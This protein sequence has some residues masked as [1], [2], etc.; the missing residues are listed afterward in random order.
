MLPASSSSPGP[1]CSATPAM[2]G[3]GVKQRH[4]LRRIL[5]AGL[6]GNGHGLHPPDA[7]GLDIKRDPAGRQNPQIRGPP[8]QLIASTAGRFQHMLTVVEHQQRPAARHHLGHGVKSR[9]RPGPPDSHPLN[10]GSNHLLI[11][12]A[13]HQVDVARQLRP[14]GRYLGPRRLNRQS[15][16]PDPPD[17]G[18]GH[19]RIAPE[20][21]GDLAEIHGSPDKGK[22]PLRQPHHRPVLAGDLPHQPTLTPRSGLRTSRFI[23]ALR[24]GGR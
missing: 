24:P 16:L 20:P 7:F 23:A 3:P 10:Q 18:Q 22:P 19:H 15:G 8:G 9:G 2:A 11:G 6:A 17:A 4:R 14:A 13:R 12:A 5:E 21:G 1:A